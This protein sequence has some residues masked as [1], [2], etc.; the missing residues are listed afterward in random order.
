MFRFFF[1]LAR[2]LSLFSFDFLLWLKRNINC[3]PAIYSNRLL[4]G[5]SIKQIAHFTVERLVP[6]PL[7]GNNTGVDFVLL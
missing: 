5:Q 1:F 7:G 6:W 3:W 4:V 2:S